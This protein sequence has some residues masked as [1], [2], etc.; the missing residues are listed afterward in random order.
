[1]KADE[2]FAKAELQLARRIQEIVA[3]DCLRRI[4]EIASLAARQIGEASQNIVGA[5]YNATLERVTAVI[6]ASVS[7][8]TQEGGQL[9]FPENVYRSI[10]AFQ[11]AE[12]A[13]IDQMA[14]TAMLNELHR[15]LT[16]SN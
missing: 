6:K 16:G 2:S 11:T 8:I 4:S 14:P 3:P 9:H 15:Y 12:M 13:R 10:I 1:M 7:S 5:D